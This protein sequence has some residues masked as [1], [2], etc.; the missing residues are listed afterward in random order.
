MKNLRLSFVLV[1]LALILAIVPAVFAQEDTLGASQGDFTLWTTAN[2]NLAT[3]STASYNFTASLEA[4]GMENSNLSA[5]LTGTGVLST[6]QADPKFQLD[7]TGSVVQG[8]TTTP[9][10][11]GVRIV[12]GNIYYNDG[13]GWKGTTLESA[14]AGISGELG[15]LTGASGASG[16]GDLSG[17][18]GM[19]GVG[20]ALSSLESLKPSD[21]LK[22]TRVDEG[23][24]AHFTLT[25][26]LAK[27]LSSPAFG[28]ILKDVM[29]MSGGSGSGSGS[30]MT[31]AQ[32]QQYQAMFSGMFSSATIA[33]DQ[34]VDTTANLAQRTALTI[35]L[36]LDMMV[37][38]G[39]AIA[40]NFDIS[41]SNINQ[42]VT[43]E[44]PA[45]AVM[46]TPSS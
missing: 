29:S 17:L 5:K 26:D 27:L 45:D 37:G 21:F 18:A 33:L 35:N 43:V 30:A 32:L 31:D 10:N 28:P 19:S 24:Q 4:S 44:A 13:T 3:I 16:S 11:L 34:Y 7:V 14:M 40:L 12:G 39:A 2:A 6:D 1:M 9:V 41:L 42:P 15:G 8:D 23:G 36:P 22:L 25:V 20:D 46:Q 38:P